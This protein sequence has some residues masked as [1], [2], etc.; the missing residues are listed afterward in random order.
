M[1][2]KLEQGTV[3][4]PV[5]V[6][7]PEHMNILGLLMRGLLETNLKQPRLANRARHLK[8]DVAVRAGHMS[9]TLRFEGTR[10]LILA[11]AHKPGSRAAD[12]PPPK[13]PRARV[14]G[15][16]TALLEMVAGGGLVAPV[17]SRRVQ[18]SGNL[19][20]L[21]KMLPLIRAPR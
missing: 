15:D 11:D 17:V 19:L 3:A 6:D 8:G 5:E 1:S 10:L 18:V 12:E 21:L 9:V 20:M 4:L 13:K 16:M 2:D 7:R 14:Q